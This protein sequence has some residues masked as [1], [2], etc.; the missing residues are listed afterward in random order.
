VA[1]SPLSH[2]LS[3]AIGGSATT[4][5]VTRIDIR[6]ANPVILLCSDGLTKHVS[7]EE[8]EQ[9]VIAMQSSEQ[10]CRAL[11]ELSLERG[12]RDNITLVVGRVMTP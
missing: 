9:Y 8:I 7:N 5:V 11:L 3:S 4:P 10:L 12:G 2:V 1:E 6:G